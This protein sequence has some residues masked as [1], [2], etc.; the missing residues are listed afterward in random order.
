MIIKD[1]T[2]VNLYNCEIA[3]AAGDGIHVVG[4]WTNCK[5]YNN[6]FNA[7]AKNITGS[8]SA[9][10]GCEFYNNVVDGWAGFA[11]WFVDINNSKFYNNTFNQTAT[12]GGQGVDLNGNA[13]GNIIKNNIMFKVWVQLPADNVC[14]Y[15][16][17]TWD[18]AEAAY[19]AFGGAHSIYAIDPMLD[20]NYKPTATSPVVTAGDAADRLSATDKAGVTWASEMGA[21]AYVAPVVIPLPSYALSNATISASSAVGAAVGTFSATDGVEGTDYTYAL[22]AGGDNFALSADGALT[23]KV[24][25]AAGTYTV[26]VT[27]SDGIT[28]STAKDFTITVTAAPAPLPSFTLS[29][30]TISASSESGAAVG[31][32]SA[33]DGVEGTDYTYALMA[34]TDNFALSTDGA[35]TTKATLAAGTYTVS[36]TISDGITTSEEADFTITVTAAPVPLPSFTLSKSSVY[37]SSAAGTAVGTFSA[38]DGVEG[39]TYTYALTAGGDKFALTTA[40]ALTT[41]AALAAGTYT[42]SV[43]ISDGKATSTATDFTITATTAALPTFTLSNKSIKENSVIGATIGTFSATN[44]VNGITYTY[45]LPSGKEDNASF[46]LSGTTLK[47]SKSFNY[48]SDA[49]YT[50]EVAI[51]DGTQTSTSKFT[52]TI[53]NVDESTSNTGGGSNSGGGTTTPTTTTT[54]S[55]G[56]GISMGGGA[57]SET[58]TSTFS[59]IASHW[60][61]SAIEDVA[62]AGIISGYGDGTVK[63]QNNASRAEF[64]TMIVRL[65][66]LKGMATSDFTDVNTDAWYAEAISVAVA[67]GLVNGQGSGKF[68]PNATITREEAMVMAYNALVKLNVLDEADASAL[69]KYADNGSVSSWAKDAAAILVKTGII[70]GSDGKLNPKA[71]ITRAEICVIIEKIMANYMS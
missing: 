50:I 16:C 43:T 70:S 26:S 22:T 46:T 41:K 25:L 69:S 54:T 30:A 61:K 33:T 48:E 20:D 66:N 53:I 18:G 3:N 65:L 51:S 39:T 45:S 42:V 23:T 36:V 55:S 34:G 9:I 58:G 27:I 21:F 11:T 67:N 8:S 57:G 38:T 6:Y 37:A 32:F 13:K 10:T 14:D 52:I 71:N 59:D 63:P 19:T 1:A 2:N 12:D 64:T 35:L 29:N 31:T 5:F 62:A 15:N 56:L 24:A 49:S 60:A 47:A 40:G 44:P 4:T 7:Y 28:T 17:Y 68:S